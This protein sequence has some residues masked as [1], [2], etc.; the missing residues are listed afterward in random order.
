[1]NRFKDTQRT[2]GFEYDRINIFNAVDP[3]RA[4][5]G[6]DILLR[7]PVSLHS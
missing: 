7:N 3:P 6:A 5:S 1:M 2:I 4:D